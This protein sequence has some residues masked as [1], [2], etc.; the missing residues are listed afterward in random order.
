M[1]VNGF[2]AIKEVLMVVGIA[3]A[4]VG[5]VILGAPALVCGGGSWN[6]SCGSNGDCSHQG[7]LGPD[8]RIFQ[9]IPDKLSELGS[10]IA[11]WGSGVLNSIGEFI[12]SVVKRI[13][14]LEVFD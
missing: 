13:Y 3:L 5:A 12:D 14:L 2:S 7:T 4:A 10:A 11:E 8:C 9:S 6:C 1:F